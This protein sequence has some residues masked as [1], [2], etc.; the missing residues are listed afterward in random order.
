MVLVARTTNSSKWTTQ[1]SRKWWIF[2][3]LSWPFCFRHN[4]W[5][6]HLMVYQRLDEHLSKTERSL[7]HHRY[8]LFD[9][10]S[11]TP[12]P[13]NNSLIV[14]IVILFLFC[15]TRIGSCSRSAM[16]VF[17][18]LIYM[19]DCFKVTLLSVHIV[20]MSS[21]SYRKYHIVKGGRIIV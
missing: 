15:H 7:V 12:S 8:I 9:K 10:I 16:F 21:A 3:H 5:G 4:S 18:S 20:E 14:F 11:H 17:I 19:A 1:S 6:L 2:N 13:A